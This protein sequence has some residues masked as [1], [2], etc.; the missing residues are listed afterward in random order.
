MNRPDPRLHLPVLLAVAALVLG[1]CLPVPHTVTR[2]PAVTGVY[3]HGD[4]TP[5]AGARMALSTEP[6]DR[7]CTEASLWT[8]T[9]A[10]GQFEFPPARQRLPFVVLLP[11][12]AYYCYN[13]CGG[14]APSDPLHHRCFGRYLPKSDSIACRLWLRPGQQPGP[15]APSSGAKQ[16]RESSSQR[17][18]GT[19]SESA[20]TGAGA[21]PR[22][23]D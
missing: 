22:S 15:G 21:L 12:D 7:T 14:G 4:G 19:E 10:A 11:F 13:V 20:A 2:S 9:D 23:C 18:V 1:A 5:V 17:A 6:N 16:T 3:R 8:V